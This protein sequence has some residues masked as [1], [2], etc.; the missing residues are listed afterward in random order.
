[1]WVHVVL[2][3]HS[4]QPCYI[5]VVYYV[6]CGIF[7]VGY[8][9]HYHCAFRSRFPDLVEA[10]AAR[11]PADGE[12][13]FARLGGHFGQQLGAHGPPAG[14]RRSLPHRADAE[15]V[16]LAVGFGGLRLVPRMGGA[17]ED[18]IVSEHGPGLSAGE[19]PLADVEDGGAGQEGDIGP[20]VDGEQLPVPPGCILERLEG[21]DLGT[22][23]EGL[24]AQLDDV[25]AAGVGGV[26]ELGKIALSAPGIGA[27]V[28]ARPAQPGLPRSSQRFGHVGVRS[29]IRGHG[30]R[31]DAVRGRLR[32]RR[33]GHEGRP[34]D[35]VRIM[36]PE[37]ESMHVIVVGAGIIGLTTAWYLRRLGAGVTV[38]DPAPARGASHA[39]AGMLAPA[40]EVVWGQTSLYRLL[41]TAGEMHPEFAA[42]VAGAA[43]A[44]LGLT[45]TG[46][47]VCAGDRA[48]LQALRELRDAQTGA[49]FSTDLITG[50]RAPELQ[51]SLSPSVAG[52]VRIP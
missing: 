13:G 49:G 19:V 24:V 17:A 14:F 18:H 25:D 43:D 7:C 42:E 50:T 39:A 4:L 41:R 36:P 20:V 44:D 40:A 32:T 31:G 38:I 48:D 47:V 29:N 22:G 51:P 28:E 30:G 35:L 21:R 23:L 16:D 2:P 5:I 6:C 45:D 3:W 10:G 27:R 34:P 33:S 11:D 8:R 26:K 1:R 9:T 12:P 52:A 37:G 15:G 46:T